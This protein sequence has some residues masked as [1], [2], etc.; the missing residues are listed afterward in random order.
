MRWCVWCVCLIGWCMVRV[1]GGTWCDAWWFRAAGRCLWY[2]MSGVGVSA[3][4]CNMCWVWVGVGCVLCVV[5]CTAWGVRNIVFVAWYVW[6]SV[7]CLQRG[8]SLVDVRGVRC[9][10]CCMVCVLCRM[11]CG[12]W[13][14]T[15]V[16]WYCAWCVVR[17]VCGMLSVRYGVVYVRRCESCVV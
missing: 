7:R 2:D 3:V 6:L 1:A 10:V 17:V 5:R 14:V 11:V 8:G 12:V 9:A 4:W 15:C 13:W 16:V